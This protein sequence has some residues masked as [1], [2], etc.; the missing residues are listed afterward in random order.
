MNT[1]QSEMDELG[2]G[3]QKGQTSSYKISHGGI[4]YSMLT[5]INHTVVHI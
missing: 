1:N 2:E 4:T 3:G 5:V